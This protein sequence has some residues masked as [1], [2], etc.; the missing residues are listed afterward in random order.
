MASLSLAASRTRN[1]QPFTS[2]LQ[3]ITVCGSFLGLK[4]FWTQKLL[5]L[6]SFLDL[7][8]FWTLRLFGPGSFLDLEAFWTLELFELF[9]PG[10]LKLKALQSF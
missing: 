10:S 8:A 9:G 6:G 2:L 4:A 7:K 5:G 3:L 1:N